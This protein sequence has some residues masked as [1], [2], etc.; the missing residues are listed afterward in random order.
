L[1]VVITHKPD[2]EITD[3]YIIKHMKEHAIAALQTSQYYGEEFQVYGIEMRDNVP[4]YYIC[5]NESSPFPIPMC[6]LL[7]KVL[8]S[9]VSSYWKMRVG[10]Y[11]SDYNVSTRFVFHEWF[12]SR[13]FYED[14]LNGDPDAEATFA[15]YK[16]LMDKEFS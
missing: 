7:C 3:P 5:L 9:R 16:D 12:Q 15:K 10:C 8:D 14:L 6:G 11:L 4:Y 2:V 13:V 1:R